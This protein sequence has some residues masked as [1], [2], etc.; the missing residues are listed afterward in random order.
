MKVQEKGTDRRAEVHINIDGQ[1]EALEEYGEYIDANDKAICCYVPIEEGHRVKFGGKFSGTTLVVAFDAVVDGVL[2][3]S[4]VYRAKSVNVQKY[5]KLDIE[6]FLYNS[7]EGLLDTEMHVATL[8][9]EVVTS[10]S[11]SIETIGTLELHVYVTRQL[12]IEHNIGSVKTYLEH[13]TSEREGGTAAPI[14]HYKLIAPSLQMTFETNTAPLDSSKV[15][16]EQR[17]IDAPRPGNEPWAVFRFHYRSRDAIELQKLERSYDP[18]VKETSEART[19]ALEEVPSLAVGTK[20]NK[21]DD[22]TSTRASSLPPDRPSTPQLGLLEDLIPP[23]KASSSKPA[24]T[25]GKTLDTTKTSN[26]NSDRA[27]NTVSNSKPDEKPVAISVTKPGVPPK[28]A[29]ARTSSNLINDGSKK[30]KGTAV[31]NTTSAKKRPNHLTNIGTPESKRTKLDVSPLT[32]ISPVKLSRIESS[33]PCPRPMPIE[34]Q[35]AEQR[36]RLQELR[37]K[38]RATAKKQSTIDKQLSPYKKQ[39]AEELDRLNKEL[40]EEEAACEE[41]EQHYTASV[42]LLKEFEEDNK[43]T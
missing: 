21:Q 38:R 41:D 9:K 19:L 29:A 13:K 43:E 26:V 23:A 15:R 7:K 14:A 34:R 17:K 4:N 16:S 10:Q 6:N 32:P 11:E 20:P 2:R 27:T 40:E 36:K 12:S 8:P 37:Q 31:E 1:V 24:E 28:P 42:S 5:K 18:K 35:V 22:D 33:S 30:T 3:K 25:D 39:M